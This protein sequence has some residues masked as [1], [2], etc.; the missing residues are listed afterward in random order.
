MVKIVKKRASGNLFIKKSNFISHIFPIKNDKEAKIVI[1]KVRLK[2]KKA[3]HCAFAYTSGRKHENQGISDDKEPSG[4][5][6]KP[7]L[8]SIYKN[9]LINVLIIVVRYFGGIKLGSG[10]LIRA[11]SKSASLAIK[12]T[13]ALNLKLYK[14]Y[15]VVLDYSFYKKFLYY[16]KIYNIVIEKTWF[17]NRITVIIAVEFKNCFKI[18]SKLKNMFAGKAQIIKL[19]RKWLPEKAKKY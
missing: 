10:G 5:A 18:I 3:N 2:N 12:K 4:T 16:G 7:I 15:K 11:Y 9:H 19:K 14:E 1:R 6:G 17:T 13:K 8:D